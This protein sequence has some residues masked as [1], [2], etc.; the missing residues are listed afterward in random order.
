MN[1]NKFLEKHVSQI[2]GIIQTACRKKN[3]T[4]EQARDFRSYVYEKLLENDAKRL[5]DFQGDFKTSWISYLSIVITRLAID[6]I[7]KHWGRWENSAAAKLLGEPAMRLETLIY[8]DKYTYQEACNI[9]LEIPEF[10][11]L[12]RLSKLELQQLDEILPKNIIQKLETFS[13][14]TIYLRYDFLMRLKEQLSEPEQ[15]HIEQI[16]EVAEFQ[17][18]NLIL[19]EW[20]LLLQGRIPARRLLATHISSVKNQDDNDLDLVENMPD[21]FNKGP[22]ESLL[23]EEIKTQLD[24][25]LDDLINELN[26]EDWSILSFYLIDNLRIS[27]IARLVG[28]ESDI[29]ENR[30]P[31]KDPVSSKNW[32]QINKRISS[33]NK[34]IRNRVKALNIEQDDRETVILYCLNLISKK[35]QK[36]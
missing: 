28:I 36:K 8:R 10:K 11:A 22:L 2:D 3:I 27:E 16:Q 34:I 7:K 13:Q 18:D 6:F 21:L 31:K 17:I 19:E 24:P 26:D 29:A 4:G 20:D 5:K 14:S 30:G 23:N 35:I 12:Y 25:M 15:A 33:V 32:K 1:V 9:M